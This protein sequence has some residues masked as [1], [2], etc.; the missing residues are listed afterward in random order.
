MRISDLA[1]LIMEVIVIS[2]AYSTIQLNDKLNILSLIGVA[3]VGILDLI[4]IQCTFWE[5]NC[6]QDNS[7]GFVTLIRP[8]TSF[9]LEQT[10][11]RKCHQSLREIQFFVWNIPVHNEMFLTIMNDIIL[12]ILI[13]LLLA[14]V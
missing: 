1:L 7:I 6:M 11:D 3:F 13:D 4:V 12:G 10:Y 9:S 8:V 5:I 2:A 14:S